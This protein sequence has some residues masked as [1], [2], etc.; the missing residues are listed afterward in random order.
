M[1]LFRL[2]KNGARYELIRYLQHQYTRKS[3][4]KKK[5]MGKLTTVIHD[6]TAFVTISKENLD[7]SCQ[8]LDMNRNYFKDGMFFLCSA[9][10]CLS[11]YK[12]L[13]K[14]RLY[15]YF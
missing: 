6:I 7:I 4:S 15:F 9:L 3:D 2:M 8:N 10:N 11:E 5:K 13:N 12:G 14:M 1:S